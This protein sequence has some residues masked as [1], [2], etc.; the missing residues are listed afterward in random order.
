MLTGLLPE[1]LSF[2]QYS[3]LARAFGG[4]AEERLP[5]E[6][7]FLSSASTFRHVCL[8]HT[9]LAPLEEKVGSLI[10]SLLSLL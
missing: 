1:G 7:T 6:W 2:D 10:P 4:D 3:E 8:Q 9:P 5:L